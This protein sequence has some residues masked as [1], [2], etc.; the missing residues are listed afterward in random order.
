MST[1]APKRRATWHNAY[2][3]QM[4]LWRWYR[5]G[6]GDRWLHRS[7]E[8]NS[9]QLPKH[10]RELELTLYRIEELKILNANPVFVSADMCDLVEFAA[11][12]FQPEPLYPTDLL[13]AH[14]FMYFER[15]FDVLDRFDTPLTIKAISWTPL[16]GA[17]EDESKREGAQ[18]LLDELGSDPRDSSAMLSWLALRA[19][20]QGIDPDG[21]SFIDGLG[22]TIYSE[23]KDDTRELLPQYNMPDLV[24]MHLTPW[25]FGMSFDGNE[26]DLHGEPTGAGWWWRIAQTTLRLMQQTIATRYKE[27]PDRATRRDGAR[28][29]FEERDVVVVRL[30]RER[31][32]RTPDDGPHSDANYSHRFIV[33]GHWRNQWYPASAMH[34]QIWISPYVKGDESLPLVVRPKRVYTWDR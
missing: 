3:A 27:R 29:G 10:T 19:E 32:P 20:D 17:G 21:D 12:S 33:N 18:K 23:T 7:F 25:W 1:I 8:I 34:R 15:G 5:T 31:D 22:I 28:R 14:G 16:L 4:A 26:V 2:D 6:P 13:D 30:R 9:E 24:P 11:L